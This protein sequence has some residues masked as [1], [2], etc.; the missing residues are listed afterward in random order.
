MKNN[1]ILYVLGLLMVIGLSCEPY[2]AGAGYQ[3]LGKVDSIR[4]VCDRQGEYVTV[5][6]IYPDTFIVAGKVDIPGKQRAYVWVNATERTLRLR[7]LNRI[8]AEYTIISSTK[9]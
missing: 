8:S 1:L 6:T 5:I 9:R 2:G 3:Y 7:G 4:F